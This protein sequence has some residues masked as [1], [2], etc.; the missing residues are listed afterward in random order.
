M[1]NHDYWE[2][3]IIMK[4]KVMTKPLKDI[5]ALRRFIT[6]RSFGMDA[7]MR[8]Y[9]V[10]PLSDYLKSDAQLGGHVSH[11]RILEKRHLLKRNY[12]I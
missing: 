3:D 7:L 11:Q 2:D 4:K 8:I 10:T 12:S 5:V 6:K 1:K 9:A